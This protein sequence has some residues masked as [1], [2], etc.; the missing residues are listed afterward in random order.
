MGRAGPDQTWTRLR[1]RSTRVSWPRLSR[2]ATLL[3]AVSYLGPRRGQRL[4]A[5]YACL[6]F[7]M[8][9]PSEA[10]GLRRDDCILPEA[11]WGKLD[12]ADTRPAVGKD[13]TDSGK[14]NEH[15]RLKNRPRRATRQVPIP[16]ELVVILRDHIQRHG[17]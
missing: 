3:A 11:G 7:G 2:Y 16:P 15:R 8:L 4:I 13:W 1:R 14:V 10:S 12:L 9:R 6:Y 5:F 17:V